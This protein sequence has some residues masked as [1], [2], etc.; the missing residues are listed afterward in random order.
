MPNWCNNHIE[1]SGSKENMKPIFDFF[2]ESD[3]IINEYYTKHAE[4][5]KNNP[6]AGL[7]YGS[8]IEGLERPEILVMNTLIPHDEEYKQIE[9]SGNYLLNPQ[10]SFYGTKWDFDFSEANAQDIS[11]EYISFTPST[12][13]APPSEFCQRLSKKFNV[14]VDIFYE[15]GGVGFVGKETYDNGE[16]TDSESYDDYLEGLYELDNEQFWY[17]VDSRLE[18]LEDQD[19]EEFLSDFTFVSDEDRGNLIEQFNTAKEEQE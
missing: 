1:I 14:V 5:R 12:A 4:Y 13:W 8:P 15:E 19:L 2:T 6:D 7:T 16:Q 17:E 9:E 3:K 10:T 18:Y 11:E